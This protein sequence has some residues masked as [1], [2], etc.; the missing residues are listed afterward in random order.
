MSSPFQNVGRCIYCD[1]TQPPLTRE[2]V[3]P[4][5]LGGNIAPNTFSEAMVLLRATCE[6]CRNT[7]RE[8]EDFCL[9]DMLG[10]ARARLVLNRK[11]RNKPTRPAEVLYRDGR[12]AEEELQIAD[13]PAAMMI[14]AFPTAA[15]F[16]GLDWKPPPISIRQMILNDEQRRRSPDV[17]S[18]SVTV[19]AHIPTFARM[20]SKIGLGF[21]HHILGPD[22]FEPVARNFI[23]FGTG[24]SN[25]FV[26]G[27]ED[28]DGGP[29][30][31]LQSFHEAS[32]WQRNGYLVTVIRLFAQLPDTPINYAVVG[33]ILRAPP[34]LPHLP[35]GSP[36]LRRDR[37]PDL[38]QRVGPTTEIQWGRMTRVSP[39]SGRPDTK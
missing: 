17:E 25:H 27:Y 38:P 35:P 34:G 37:N 16:Q 32:L 20:L 11:D 22:A 4:R 29:I 18:V 28:M 36:S 23:R 33:R 26:G 31:S 12:R 10:H 13:I 6:T 21:A 39:A 30:G 24:H 7:T 15:V 8:I 19:T 5:G 3:I 14:P 9:N 1:S 2:H